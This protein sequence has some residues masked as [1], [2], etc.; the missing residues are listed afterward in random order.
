M[1]VQSSSQFST[2]KIGR[3]SDLYLRIRAYRLLIRNNFSEQKDA[4]IEELSQ[5]TKRLEELIKDLSKQIGLFNNQ[6]Q[7]IQPVIQNYQA[8]N[9]VISNQ[10]NMKHNFSSQ[11][12]QLG[13]QTDEK[14]EVQSQNQNQMQQQISQQHN[15]LSNN[16]QKKEKWIKRVNILSDKMQQSS[17][18][19]SIQQID[20]RIYKQTQ[21]KVLKCYISCNSWLQQ[22]IQITDLN[23]VNITM[24]SKLQKK[25]DLYITSIQD[26]LTGISYLGDM[27]GKDEGDD[28][29]QALKQQQNSINLRTLF[30]Y[31]ANLLCQIEQYDYLNLFLKKSKNEKNLVQLL[32]QE[33]NQKKQ[34]QEQKDAVIEELSQTKKRLEEMIRD[35]SKQIGSFKNQQQNIQPVIQNYQANN[36]VFSNQTNM[37]HNFSSQNYQLGQQTD[38]KEEVQSQNQKQMQQQISQQQ[39]VLSNKL[40]TISR[41]LIHKLNQQFFDIQNEQHVSFQDYAVNQSIQIKQN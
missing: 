1:I 19:I 34:Q 10:T 2:Y 36:Q 24:K 8:N 20:R 31:T 25:L 17:V 33:I 27:Q 11:N 12:Y 14:E 41:F 13:Q 5:T 29:N 23:Y 16:H 9:Q 21:M 32:N 15:L 3:K 28:F 38:E 40:Q 35:L 22:K 18:Q 37:K 30:S 39:N 4:V 26:K 6:Q 7:N